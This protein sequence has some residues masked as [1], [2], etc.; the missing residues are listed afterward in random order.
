MPRIPIIMPQLGESIAEATIV[1]LPF[2]VGDDVEADQD[3]IE[4]ETNKATMGVTTPCAG[5]HRGIARW[6]CEQ[7]YP[8][9]T[10]LGYLEVTEEDATR[11]RR[12]CAAA[13]ETGP[14]KI[15]GV[16]RARPR[17]VQ[18]TVRGLPVPAHAAGASYM[19]P[20]DEGAHERT[21]PA[22]RRS[23]GHRRQR[24]GAAA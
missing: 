6:S 9:G 7:S 16:A 2:T 19:S 8:V 15:D 3:I 4:V 23:R 21:R 10:T 24:R 22:R 5:K 12:R 14:A 17:S 13:L 18:P 20:A 1:R 11:R